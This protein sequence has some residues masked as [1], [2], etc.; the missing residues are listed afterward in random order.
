MPVYD[1]SLPTFNPEQGKQ[2]RAGP[3]AR[4]QG[5]I[6]LNLYESSFMFVG[7]PLLEQFAMQFWPP[8]ALFLIDSTTE[9]KNITI[10]QQ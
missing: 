10:D 5:L 8:K 2:R 3:F 9:L 6:W 7:S 4:N 1:T